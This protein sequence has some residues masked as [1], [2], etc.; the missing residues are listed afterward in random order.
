MVLFQRTSSAASTMATTHS[1]DDFNRAR[2]DYWNLFYGELSLVEGPCVKR[3]MEVFSQCAPTLPIDNN[4]Q[5]PM[6]KLEQPSY[7]LTNRMK[8]EL[9]TSWEAP[10]SELELQERPSS[11]DFEKESECQ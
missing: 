2:T 7:R 11:C 3:A 9:A 5:L 4:V 1:I 10:F 8:G 6:R